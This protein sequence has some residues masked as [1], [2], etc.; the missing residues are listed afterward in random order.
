MVV[1][2]VGGALAPAAP[3]LPS[4]LSQNKPANINQPFLSEQTSS[5]HQPNEQ[6]ELGAIAVYFLSFALRVMLQTLL[7]FRITYRL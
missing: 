3:P 5:S 4:P 2:A 7:V 6:T 1:A